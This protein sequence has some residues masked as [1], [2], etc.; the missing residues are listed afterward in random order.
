[1]GQGGWADRDS[2]WRLSIDPCIRCHFIWGAQGGL[3]SDRGAQVPLPL[4][5]RPWMAKL[6]SNA[7]VHSHILLVCHFFFFFLT[8]ISDETFKRLKNQI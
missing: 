7:L 8:G 5:L 1:M 6:K 3:A 4:R 2:K